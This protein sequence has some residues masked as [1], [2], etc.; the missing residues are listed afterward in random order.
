MTVVQNHAE[1][2]SLYP[3]C[4]VFPW[5]ALLA[6]REIDASQNRPSSIHRDTHVSEIKILA[7]PALKHGPDSEA[8]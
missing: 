8:D 3:G 5:S 6:F 4:I 7:N 1:Q 2:G